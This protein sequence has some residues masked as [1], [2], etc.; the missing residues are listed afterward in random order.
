MA[1]KGTLLIIVVIVIIAAIV[2]ISNPFKKAPVIEGEG[3]KNIGDVTFD[4][5]FKSFEGQD[6][7][8]SDF[9]GQVIVANAWAAWCPFCIDE[10]PVLQAV[11]DNHGDDVVVLFIHR[12]ATESKSRATPYLDEFIAEGTP[13]TDP[14]LEDPNDSFY[15]TFFGFGMPVTL[16]IDKDGVIRDKKTGPLT[17]S[18]LEGKIANLL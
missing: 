1:K 11:S 12:T 9:R 5:Q 16:F 7:K 4:L 3:G 18:E 15:T 8:F 10:M 13:I 2:I 17:E 14:V 6:V